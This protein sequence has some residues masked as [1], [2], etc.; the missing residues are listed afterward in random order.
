MHKFLARRSRTSVALFLIS[1]I[2]LCYW[3][4]AIYLLS[5]SAA[6]LLSSCELAELGVNPITVLL[7]MSPIYSM[8]ILETAGEILSPGAPSRFSL[9][10]DLVMLIVIFTQVSDVLQYVGGKISEHACEKV[11]QVLRAELSNFKLEFKQADFGLKSPKELSEFLQKNVRN[12]YLFEVSPKKTIT[13]YAF[14]FWGCLAI[15]SWMW[16]VLTWRTCVLWFLLGCAGDLYAS[17]IKRERGVKDF[18]RTLGA[19]GGMLDRFDS[20]LAVLHWNYWINFAASFYFAKFGAAE[21]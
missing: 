15:F 18:S 1:L 20:T 11:V 19:H 6:C 10:R 3:S 7:Y 12:F 9:G 16:D 14:G 4:Q 13:G 17:S 5:A 8:T 21:L 2:P